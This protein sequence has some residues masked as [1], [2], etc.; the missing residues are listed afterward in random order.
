M[1]PV[2]EVLDLQTDRFGGFFLGSKFSAFECALWPH[3]QRIPIILG[4][5]RGVRLDDDP[6][7]ER[8]DM[9]A[10]AVAARPSVRRTIVDEARLMDNYSGYADGSAT[11][12]AAKKY[13][14]N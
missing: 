5:Y 11:S 10:K 6:R 14:K 8:M 9:W 1:D 13:A 7:L 12:D 3:Y 2:S 4:T